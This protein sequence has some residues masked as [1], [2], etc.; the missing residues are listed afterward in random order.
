VL[1]GRNAPGTSARAVI[2]ALEQAGTRVRL[3]LIDICDLDAMRALLAD[4]G[5]DAPLRGIVHA[6]GISA[7][8][9]VRTLDMAAIREARRGKVG[10]AQ[11]L[12]HATSGLALDFVVLCSSAAGLFGG[13]GQGAYVAANAE[14]EAVAAQWRREGAPVTTVAWGPW[15]EGG[16]FARLPAQARSAWQ[17]RGLRPMPS[18]Q[19][20]AALE[21]VLA[22]GEPYAVA[23]SVDWPKLFALAPPH[24]QGTLFA[25]FEP[26]PAAAIVAHPADD[27]LGRLRALPSGLQR[28][29][30][31]EALARRTRAVLELPDG[32]SLPAA[33]PLKQFGL[34]SLMAV[35]L[36]N[37]LARFGGVPLPATLV[38]DHP[39]LEALAERLSSVWQLRSAPALAAP[40]S[41]ADNELDAISETE[42]EAL[43][44]A[45][46]A[47]LSPEP[48]HWRRP[49]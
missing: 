14:L 40:P 32:V 33:T 2:A 1:V 18:R 37:Q 43:L 48:A 27:G 7:D 16:M 20:L 9:L 11:A 44:A 15:A 8:G 19:A 49:Q 28:P 21:F 26:E 22:R 34:D 39:T 46:L 12:R 36:R 30:L 42:A 23:A 45:E 4:V 17:A 47:A 3:A 13:L 25:A 29:A 24:R 41:P 35:E 38:F 5:R 31:I 6:A 10:G